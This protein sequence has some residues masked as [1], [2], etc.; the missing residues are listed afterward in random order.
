MEINKLF[1]IQRGWTQSYINPRIMYLLDEKGDQLTEVY[2]VD[3]NHV[4]VGGRKSNWQRLTVRTMDEFN[5][6][7]AYLTC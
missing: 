5:H 1:L 4:R 6:L 2:L 3:D 7:V